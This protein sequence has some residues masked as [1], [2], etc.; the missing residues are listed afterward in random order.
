M[1]SRESQLQAFDRLLTIMDEL[2]T[3]CPWDKKQTMQTLRHLTIEETYELGD[4]ILDNDLEEIKKELG[5]VLLHIVFYAKI[6]SETKH[7]DIADVANDICDKLINRHPH[8]YGDVVVENEEEV[9]QNW[10]KIKLKEGKKSVLEG[11]PKG[12]P[13]LVKANRI[14]D[15][16]AGVGFDWEK[17]EQVW[18]KVQEELEEFQ[19]EVRQG[20]ADAMESEFGDVLF[21]MVNYARFLNINPENA[22]ER[23][24]KKFIKRFQ[25]LEN[26][27]KEQGKALKDMTLSEMDVFWEEAKTI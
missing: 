16:V 9:K 12:L 7:F 22:L 4:A 25:Y 1:N 21:S 18:E 14:Q 11:V 17:P 10:E 19:D 23:T 3:Q 8:I 2:R 15:K 27:A 20:N 13:A 24:N 26:K 6:G 5:D